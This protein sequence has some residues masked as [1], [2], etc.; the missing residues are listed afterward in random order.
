MM[1]PSNLSRAFWMNVLWS[2]GTVSASLLEPVLMS[3]GASRGTLNVASFQK[4]PIVWQ[5]SFS[6]ETPSK[7]NSLSPSKMVVGKL[8]FLGRLA[9]F[10]CQAASVREYVYPFMYFVQCIYRSRLPEGLEPQK[11]QQRHGVDRPIVVRVW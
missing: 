9:V 5:Q 8:L 2:I 7:T 4:F 3:C 1:I 6:N 11:Q 10:R